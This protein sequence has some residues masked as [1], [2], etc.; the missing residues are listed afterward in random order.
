M[1]LHEKCL[2]RRLLASS[3][4]STRTSRFCAFLNSLRWDSYSRVLQAVRG[5]EALKVRMCGDCA[6][7]EPAALKALPA[8]HVRFLAALRTHTRQ[9]LH[10]P[11]QLARWQLP[12]TWKQPRRR[13]SPCNRRTA[14]HRGYTRAGRTRSFRGSSLALSRRAP[15][16]HNSNR[17]SRNELCASCAEET[18][19]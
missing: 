5:S 1:L 16:M 12:S 19:H 4:K 7:R 9:P 2:L 8:R 15:A 10:C 18:R 17:E 3:A 6:R 13:Q 14:H 11:T